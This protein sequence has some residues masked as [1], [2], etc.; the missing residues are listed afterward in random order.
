M[1]AI[2]RTVHCRISHMVK[3]YTDLGKFM[4]TWSILELLEPK[5]KEHTVPLRFPLRV[6]EKYKL[7]MRQIITQDMEETQCNFNRE[8]YKPIIQT[9]TS[10]KPWQEFYSLLEVRC[11]LTCGG[12]SC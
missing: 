5:A 12:R 6:C 11:G 1:E 2:L 10:T 3:F 4:N 9:K 7:Q 8:I